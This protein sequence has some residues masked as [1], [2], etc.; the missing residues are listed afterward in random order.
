M[1]RQ[2]K[3]VGMSTLSQNL[4]KA[5]ALISEPGTNIKN[6]AKVVLEGNKAAYCATGALTEIC[7]ADRNAELMALH[8]VLK[9]RYFSSSLPTPTH[10]GGGGRPISWAS[11]INQS[12][13][14]AGPAIAQFNNSTDQE[15]VLALFDE[16]IADVEAAEGTPSQPQPEEP[17]PTP[18]P[19]PVPAP[20]PEPAP[21]A[22]VRVLE[23]T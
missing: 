21:A 15:Q 11:L 4:R 12:I 1:L 2:S 14:W 3:G 17:A 8:A 7:G 20:V 18:E 10:S 23:L 6:Y 13:G 19:M 16:A 22:R 5:R 9:R